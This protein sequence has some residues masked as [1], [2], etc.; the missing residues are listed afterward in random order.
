MEYKY[1][2]KIINKVNVI[3]SQDFN[4]LDDI[5]DLAVGKDTIDMTVKALDKYAGLV[6]PIEI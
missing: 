3:D 1:K 2:G 6:S 5:G 4:N